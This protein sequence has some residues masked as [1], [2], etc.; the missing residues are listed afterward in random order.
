MSLHCHNIIVEVTIS[1]EA[2]LLEG[3]YRALKTSLKKTDLPILIS[4]FYRLGFTPE[5]Y[6]INDIIGFNFAV[7]V[8]CGRC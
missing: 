3:C 2:I 4:N 8:S 7:L 5:L 6:S 1:K